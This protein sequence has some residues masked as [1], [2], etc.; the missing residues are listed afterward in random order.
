MAKEKKFKP[1]RS[2]ADVF[3]NTVLVLVILVVLGLSVYAV[4]GKIQTKLAE[5]NQAGEQTEQ[6][7]ADTYTVQNA[8]DE[9]GMTFEDFTAEYGLTDVTPEDLMSSVTG[10]MTCGNYAK[11]TDTTFEDLVSVNQLPES[12]TEDTKWSEAQDLIPVGVAMG[13]E[14]QFNQMKEQLGLDDSITKDT[15]SGEAMPI[16]QEKYAEFMQAQQ[17]AA[18]EAPATEETEGAA[19]DADNT[20]DGE[21][22][23]EEPAA[24]NDNAE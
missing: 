22:A 11:Y 14:E 19:E 15:P 17:A 21:A 8:A 1:R 20:A 23:S 24:E 6:T 18:S 16:I 12:V 10:N 3:L 9:K 5:K 2:S 13:G 7:Q 4:G